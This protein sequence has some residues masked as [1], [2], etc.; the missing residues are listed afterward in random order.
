MSVSGIGIAGGCRKF[1]RAPQGQSR[2]AGR[3]AQVSTGTP[4]ASELG[5][6]LIAWADMR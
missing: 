6:L 4:S 5:L 1:K 2:G 3:R